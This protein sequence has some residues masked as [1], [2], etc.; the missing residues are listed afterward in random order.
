[1]SNNTPCYPFQANKFNCTPHINKYVH[2]N[3]IFNFTPHQ[4]IRKNYFLASKN[5]K[6]YVTIFTILKKDAKWQEVLGAFLQTLIFKVE[7]GNAFEEFV[8]RTLR[9][10]TYISKSWQK[11]NIYVKNGWPHIIV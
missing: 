1:M 7:E 3:N 5:L 4:N 8:R 2:F 10:N 6:T 9:L 11:K